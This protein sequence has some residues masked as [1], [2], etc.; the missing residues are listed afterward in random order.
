ME[1]VALPLD[2]AEEA[3]VAVAAASCVAANAPG[4]SVPEPSISADAFAADL[5]DALEAADVAGEI[6]S[7]W[8]V[9]VPV[10]S[11]PEDES[12]AA[13]TAASRVAPEAVALPVGDADEAVTIA[14]PAPADA[15]NADDIWSALAALP[16][17]AA[18]A[19]TGATALS[20]ATATAATSAAGVPGSNAVEGRVALLDVS[21]DAVPEIGRSLTPVC[22]VEA[23]C[24]AVADTAVASE[25]A[26]I[27]VSDTTGLPLML[28][29]AVPAAVAEDA[30]EGV[31]K[32]VAFPVT[33][34]PLVDAADAAVAESGSTL[35]PT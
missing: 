5:P 31:P 30:A 27:D 13:A 22:R 1:F 21:A 29:G 9:P 28:T 18:A 26:Q 8:N 3:V 16:K 4:I 12:G 19:V 32:T 35:T 25:W 7:A 17:D 33:A 20:A 11:A 34:D 2:A 14:L 10:D 24:K 23:L 6:P 15:V